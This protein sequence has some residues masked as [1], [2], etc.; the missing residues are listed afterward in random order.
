MVQDIT[1]SDTRARIDGVTFTYPDSGDINMSS[2]LAQLEAALIDMN[3]P[4]VPR[5]CVR[6]ITEETGRALIDGILGKRFLTQLC[7]YP[8]K[9]SIQIA[10]PWT[11]G[12]IFSAPTCISWDDETIPLTTAQRTEW[13]LRKKIP[14]IRYE[15]RL[16]TGAAAR[17]P[18]GQ[19]D[20]ERECCDGTMCCTGDYRTPRQGRCRRLRRTRARTRRRK[21]RTRSEKAKK[22]W[23]MIGTRRRNAEDRVGWHASSSKD[24]G[25]EWASGWVIGRKG[26]GLHWANRA[27]GGQWQADSDISLDDQCT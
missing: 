17:R 22:N 27:S 8:T 12:E 19:G 26:G 1:G 25:W 3:G 23:A 10:N 11:A 7:M 16:L 15:G 4:D 24:H 18:Q 9:V 5:L 20:D 2:V 13:V 14:T 6:S 21:R